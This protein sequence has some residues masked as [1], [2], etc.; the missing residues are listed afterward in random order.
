MFLNIVLKVVPIVISAIALTVSII[1]AWTNRRTIHV[2]ISK[3]LEVVEGGTAFFINDDGQPA[4]YDDGLLATIEVVNPSPK[5]I[6]FFDLR[7][8][9]PDTN[10]NTH[11]LTKRTMLSI[12]RT[13]TLW[14]AIE[15]KSETP[16]LMELIVPETNYGIFKANSFTRFHIL[17][18]PDKTSK[19][20]NLSFKVA[21]R[22]RIKDKFAVTGRKKFKFYGYSYNISSW[23]EPIQRQQQSTK[24]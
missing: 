12:H 23:T 2:D 20:L 4:P 6:A 18:F 21:L 13:K 15:T 11:L 14:R 7:A 3:N 22:A 17:M 19:R 10:M 16:L 8:F 5:D 9:Y 24:Q 1:V